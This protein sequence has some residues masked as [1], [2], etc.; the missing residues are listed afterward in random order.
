M[1]VGSGRGVS[2]RRT[3]QPRARSVARAA[4]TFGLTASITAS[5]LLDPGDASADANLLG[6][7][8]AAVAQH[9][10]PRLGRCCQ[11]RGVDRVEI[12]AGG[13][14]VAVGALDDEQLHGAG[15]GGDLAGELLKVPRRARRDA[16]RE[17]GEGSTAAQVYVLDLQP[18]GRSALT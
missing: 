14:G 1:A 12:G 10:H 4:P 7:D 16:V 2:A 3:V 15:A 9:L 18:T 6:A 8:L 17:L 11:A 5:G 13:E